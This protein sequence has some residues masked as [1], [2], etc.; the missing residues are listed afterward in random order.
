MSAMPILARLGQVLYSV[1]RW[2]Y[3]GLIIVGIAAAVLIEMGVPTLKVLV[4]GCGVG[5]AF[6]TLSMDM[7]DDKDKWPIICVGLLTVSVLVLMAT[8][9]IR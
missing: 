6:T 2:R 4:W 3:S 7:S 1:A 8:E 9:L 5:V